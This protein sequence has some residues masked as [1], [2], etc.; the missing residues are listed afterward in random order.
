MFKLLSLQGHFTLKPQS[1]YTPA[2]SVDIQDETQAVEPWADLLLP[3][4]LVIRDSS[5]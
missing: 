3:W 1:I 2:A 5:Q 4:L